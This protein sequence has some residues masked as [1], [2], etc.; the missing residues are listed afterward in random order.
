MGM[1]RQIPQLRANFATALRRARISAQHID[2]IYVAAPKARPRRR[3]LDGLDGQH[4]GRTILVDAD[5]D[6]PRFKSSDTKAARIATLVLKRRF[7]ARYRLFPHDVSQRASNGDQNTTQGSIIINVG[8]PACMRRFQRSGPA[9][10]CMIQ[11][12][13]KVVRWNA[14]WHENQCHFSASQNKSNLFLR[15]NHA[16]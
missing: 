12:S 16:S 3:H 6:V 9:L 15:H 7:P 8:L 1:V 4:L 5:S 14:A 11:I 13:E 2:V 10:A